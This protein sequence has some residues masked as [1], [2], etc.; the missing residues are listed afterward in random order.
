MRRFWKQNKEFSEL[1]RQLRRERPR[2]RSAYLDTLASELR[3]EQVQRSPRHSLRYRV[4]TAGALT[5]LLGIAAAASGGL[6]YAATA[7]SHTVNA[8]A[9]IFDSQSVAQVHNGAAPSKGDVQA[10]AGDD[11]SG[12]Q[13]DDQDPSADNQDQSSDQSV[14][15]DESA[16]GHGGGDQAAHHQYNP[17]VFVC[18]RIPRKHPRFFVTVLVPKSVADR[19][20]ARGRATP[21]PCK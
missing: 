4:A 20:I 1:E 11:G 7:S 21:G 3:R 19:W 12:Q 9:H 16:A 14:Q 5:V 17:L 2:P 10:S 13:A 8:V 6:S 15:G 18:L